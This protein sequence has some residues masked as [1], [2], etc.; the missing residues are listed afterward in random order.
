[1]LCTMIKELV[2]VLGEWVNSGTNSLDDGMKAGSTTIFYLMLGNHGRPG[3]CL[4][5]LL[6]RWARTVF[7]FGW[8]S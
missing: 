3:L 4:F 7:G 5:V 1:M 6:R 2:K 8:N